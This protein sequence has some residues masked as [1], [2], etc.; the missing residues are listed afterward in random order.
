LPND[1]AQARAALAALLPAAKAWLDGTLGP[2]RATP[3]LPHWPPTKA[4]TA[5][6]DYDAIR[7]DYAERIFDAF[8]SYMSATGAVTRYR[9]A[10]GK[11]VIEDFTAAFGRGIDDGGGD[12]ADIDPEDDAWLTARV[13]EEIGHLADAFDALKDL[14]ASG[15]FVEVDIQAKADVWVAS[16]DG[17]YSEAKLRASKNMLCRFDGDDGEHSCESC[18]SLK[19][20]PPRTV[21]WIL[22]HD[23]IPRPM[24][25]EFDCKCIHCMHNWFSVKTGEQM[26]F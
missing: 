18:Q 21:K 23:A 12:S 6:D 17:V 10:A 26:T 3:P 25:P 11:A 13:S 19:T 5:S 15:E 8:I 24:N 20:G 14:R 9:S 7:F 1:H 4:T 16:L 2:F 22:A